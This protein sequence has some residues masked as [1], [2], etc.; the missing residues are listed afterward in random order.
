MVLNYSRLAQIVSFSRMIVDAKVVGYILGRQYE[1]FIEVTNHISLPTSLYEISES[2]P[3]TNRCNFRIRFNYR[4]TG[5]KYSAAFTSFPT[6][7]TVA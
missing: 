5:N 2:V 6:P 3:N 7:S 1:G 4:N